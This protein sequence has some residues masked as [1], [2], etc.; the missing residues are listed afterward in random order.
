MCVFFL[1]PVHYANHQYLLAILHS[2][3]L[4]PVDDMTRRLDELEASLTA[5]GTDSATATPSQ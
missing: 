2:T 4:L 1:P 5:S 3:K